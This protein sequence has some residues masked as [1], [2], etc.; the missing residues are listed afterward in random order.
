MALPKVR[1][2][3]KKMAECEEFLLA[4]KGRVKDIRMGAQEL[5]LRYLTIPKKFFIKMR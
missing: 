5:C 2:L 3:L 1:K 4:T